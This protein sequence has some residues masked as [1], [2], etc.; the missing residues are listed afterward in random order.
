MQ[1]GYM[2][3]YDFT[4]EITAATAQDPMFGSS[5]V[6]RSQVTR[7]RVPAT[8]YGFGFDMTALTGRQTA[9]LVALG[10]ARS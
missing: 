3:C 1:Y 4:E 8:P 6:T 9:I 5:R 2:M 7:Q 10:L